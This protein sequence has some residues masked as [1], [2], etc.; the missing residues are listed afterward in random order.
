MSMKFLIAFML[1][2]G[3]SVSA[4][5]EPDLSGSWSVMDVP[6]TRTRARRTLPVTLL[7][8]QSGGKI[9]ITEGYHDG[10][11]MLYSCSLTSKCVVGTDTREWWVRWDGTELVL[12]LR[13]GVPREKPSTLRRLH[14]SPDKQTLMVK[15]LDGPDAPAYPFAKQ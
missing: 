9:D 3:V 14:L 11:S 1:L 15:M 2:V 10:N 4:N 12:E 5:A 13:S 6:A 8:K 7:I